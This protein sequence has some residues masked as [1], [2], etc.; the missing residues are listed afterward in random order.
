[1]E[2]KHY[3][4]HAQKNSRGATVTVCISFSVWHLTG[5]ERDQDIPRLEDK[6]KQGTKS[7]CKHLFIP[8]TLFLLVLNRIAA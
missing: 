2:V 8:E 6:L 7:S 3:D 1:M 5:T 4:V